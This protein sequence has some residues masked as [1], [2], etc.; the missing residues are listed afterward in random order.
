ME[1]Q[2][3]PDTKNTIQQVLKPLSFPIAQKRKKQVCY[4]CGKLPAETPEGDLTKDHLP[5]QNLFLKPRPSNLISMPCCY[6]CNHEAH[7]DDDHLR[8]AVSG[9]YNTNGL[10]KRTWKEKVIGS[11]IRTGRLHREVNAMRASLKPIALIT[12]EG[13]KDAFE[14]RVD[15]ARVDRALTRM[16]KGFL[17]L[18]YPEVDRAELNFHVAQLEQFKVNDPG[19]AHIRKALFNFQRGDGVYQC[20]YTVESYSHTGLWVHMFFGSACYGVDHLSDRKIV[21]PW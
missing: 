13:V 16:T 8:L 17:A 21:L 20:W 1:I 6:S 2:D 12:P 19:F 9:Y 4:L 14:M 5:P 18:L 7:V 11:T 15:G 3:L 10:G